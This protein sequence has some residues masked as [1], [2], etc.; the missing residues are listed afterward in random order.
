MFKQLFL[1]TLVVASTLSLSMDPY[2]TR[3]SAFYGKI[4][5]PEVQEH[6]EQRKLETIQVELKMV[7]ALSYF[8]LYTK[9]SNK[10]K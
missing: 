2:M 10:T 9:V 3:R 5:T 6:K 8:D 7:L 1:V 4:M